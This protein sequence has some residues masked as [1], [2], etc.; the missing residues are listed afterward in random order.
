MHKINELHGKGDA[1]FFLNFPDKQAE[2]SVQ[3]RTGVSLVDMAGARN[4]L[5][6]ELAI[7]YGWD[8]DQVVKHVRE[9]WNEYLSRIEIETDD[10]LQQKKF[11]SNLYR[12]IAAKASWNDRDGRIAT[13][14]SRFVSL[15]WQTWHY[16][17]RC[18]SWRRGF[19]TDEQLVCDECHRFIPDGGWLFTQAIL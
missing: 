10:Y 19:G 14:A 6:Q 15:S 8:L 17:L 18:L 11:Y 9:V 12:A 7:P 16:A 1:G 4:N 3:V 5:Q 2:S 13:S